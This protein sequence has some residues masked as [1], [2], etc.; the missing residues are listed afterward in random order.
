[1]EPARSLSSLAISLRNIT[2]VAAGGGHTC[3]LTTGGRS[4]A[5][6]AI[7]TGNWAMA[8]RSQV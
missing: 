6:A 8:Q 3:A 4:N 1:M 2:A 5:G 7:T